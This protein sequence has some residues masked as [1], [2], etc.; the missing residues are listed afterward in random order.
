VRARKKNRRVWRQEKRFQKAIAR[1]GKAIEKR[2]DIS[3]PLLRSLVSDF[4][5]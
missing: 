5:K 4:K 1:I 2:P 3:T